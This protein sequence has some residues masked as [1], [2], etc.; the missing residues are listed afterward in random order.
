MLIAITVITYEAADSIEDVLD[1]IPVRVAGE[2]PLILVSDDASSDN[3][4]DLVEKWAEGNPSVA[5]E[6]VRQDVNLGYGGNQKAAYRWATEHGAD[7]AILVHGDGQYPPELCEEL[8]RPIIDGTA[9]AVHGSRMILPG[10]A[11]KGRM[12][13]DRFMGNKALSKG[14][15]LLS[16]AEL[17]E[18]FSGYNAYRLSTLSSLDLHSL[19][20]GFDFD[21]AIS[22]RLLEHGAT[23]AEVAIPTRYGD[24]VSRVPLLRTGMATI[25]HAIRHW[26]SRRARRRA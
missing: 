16:G 11:R 18:W 12:P 26:R 5:L 6:V 21:A 4:R 3:T 23:I 2:A 22:L 13:L 14:L 7:I 25:G 20:D 10:G 15:N 19:P 9:D 1:R 17:T 24:E 8:A